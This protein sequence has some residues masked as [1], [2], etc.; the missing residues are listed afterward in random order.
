VSVWLQIVI[1]WVVGAPLVAILVGKVIAAADRAL[2]TRPVL[3]T[4]SVTGSVNVPAFAAAHQPTTAGHL[5][6]HTVIA[7]E[8][9]A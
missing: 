1:G 5:G 8:T 7:G 2:P 3:A 9:A 6:T 4:A